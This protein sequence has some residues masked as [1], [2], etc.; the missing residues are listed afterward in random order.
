MKQRSTMPAIFPTDTVTW[1][2]AKKTRGLKAKPLITL[3]VDRAVVNKFLID[4]LEAKEPI[5]SANIFCIGETGD[6]WQQTAKA[7]LKKYDVKGIDDDGWMLCEPKPENEVEFF[8]ATDDAGYI[9]GLWGATIDGVEK[10]QAFAM[11]DFICRQPHEHVDQWVVRRKLFLNTYTE[12]G[13]R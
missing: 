10:L 9:K 2:R 3:L 12:L 6:A 5:E 4:T 8:E 13:A 7:L 1:R 11:G